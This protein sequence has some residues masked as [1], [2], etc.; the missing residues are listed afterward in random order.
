VEEGRR[1]DMFAYNEQLEAD[2]QATILAA[3]APSDQTFIVES[4][5]NQTQPGDSVSNAAPIVS[6][7]GADLPS[8]GEPKKR[9]GSV[10]VREAWADD[11]GGEV[12]LHQPAVDTD[13]ADEDKVEEAP[14][15]PVASAVPAVAPFVSGHHYIQVGSF[16][17][18]GNA[19]K[20]QQLIRDV[21]VSNIATVEVAGHQW[22]RLRAGP[23]STEEQAA[24]ALVRIRA[25]GASDAR[26]LRQ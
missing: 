7:A 21:A 11:V 18:S 1:I 13:K 6:V 4:T 10:L 2:K 9:G 25:L 26:I 14:R 15:A 23:F 17:Q 19:E 16:S 5:Q 22:W 8:K 20:M 24:A 12:I 3:T